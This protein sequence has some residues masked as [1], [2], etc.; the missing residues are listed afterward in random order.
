MVN[1][2]RP[3]AASITAF[4][5][6]AAEAEQTASGLNGDKVWV[7]GL[8]SPVTRSFKRSVGQA[9]LGDPA[10]SEASRALRPQPTPLGKVQGLPSGEIARPSPVVRCAAASTEPTP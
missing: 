8:A 4:A 1:W 5:T 9:F 6:N 10:V 7:T 2:Q 3:Q